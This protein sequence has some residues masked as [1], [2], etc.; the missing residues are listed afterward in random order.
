MKE[1]PEDLVISLL[2]TYLKDALLYRN[3]R[4]SNIFIA[5]LF[6]IARSWKQ[7]RYPSV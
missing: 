4:Y 1:E 5:A 7:P 6:V 3:D 2:V